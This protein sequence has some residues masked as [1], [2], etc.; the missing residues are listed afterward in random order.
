M[1]KLN[2]KVKICVL[3]TYLRVFIALAGFEY[4]LGAAN[5]KAQLLL[6]PVGETVNSIRVDLIGFDSI[7]LY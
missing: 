3:S 2:T 5:A 4:K 6:G 1:F 7:T